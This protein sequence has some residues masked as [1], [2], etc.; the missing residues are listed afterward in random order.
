MTDPIVASVLRTLG[1]GRAGLDAVFAG[2][3]DGDLGRNIAAAVRL[4]RSAPGR[5]IVTGV[6]KSG[7]IARKLAA[8][9]SSTG[10][11]SYFMHPTEATHG[12]L[13]M[14]DPEDVVLALSWSG[15]SPNSL[16][17]SPTPSVSASASSA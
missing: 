13:G 2:V 3:A 1:I 16:A 17:S 4:I 12:D 11:P 6:G 10:T 5:L 9:M 8:T 15:K 14:I 7:H